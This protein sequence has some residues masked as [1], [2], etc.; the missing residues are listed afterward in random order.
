MSAIVERNGCLLMVRERQPG[1]RE[2]WVLPGGVAETGEL[3][4]AALAREV[5]EETGLTLAGPMSLACASQHVVTG[6]P[7]W[8]GTWT[9]LT[10]R[11]EN[12]TGTLGPL[13]PDELVLEADWVPVGEALVR[14]S[15]HPSRRR[16]EPLISCL[17]GTS[18]PGTL[19]LWPGGPEDSPVVVPPSPR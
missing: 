11:A 17:N 5:H 19:W 1:E 2:R 6:D 14:L 13:D 4:H 8:D 18:P 12:A 10:F 7:G 16:R 3:A 9:V 15:D